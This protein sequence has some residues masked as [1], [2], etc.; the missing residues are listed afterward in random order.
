[1]QGDSSSSS[2]TLGSRR[3]MKIVKRM[4]GRMSRSAER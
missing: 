1:V 2:G 4:S 3:W